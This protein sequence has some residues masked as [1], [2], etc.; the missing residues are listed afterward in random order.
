MHRFIDLFCGIGGFRVA[1]EKEG[2]ECVFSCDIDH[3]ARQAYKEN[4]AEEPNGDI[5]VVR[6]EDIPQHDIM[7]AGFPCQSFSQSG[8]MGGLDDPRGRL[9]FE[10]IRLAKYHK[11]KILLL[12]NVKNIITN[13]NGKVIDRIQKS[14]EEIGY[15]V[16]YHILNASD[17]WHSSKKRASL[18][19]LSQKKICPL[20]IHLQKKRGEKDT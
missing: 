1:L 13:D 11:P 14:L 10:I 15:L 12:E 8:K 5:T 4:F 2:M 7:C 17:I 16:H 19:C 9:F 18:F 20:T 3:H 6:S